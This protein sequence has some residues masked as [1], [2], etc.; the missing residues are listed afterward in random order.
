MVKSG[1]PSVWNVQYHVIAK[2]EISRDAD[3][4]YLAW[5]VQLECLTLR[6]EL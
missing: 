5:R 4:R 1:L 2:H 3:G 6:L